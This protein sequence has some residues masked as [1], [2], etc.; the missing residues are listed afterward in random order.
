MTIIHTPFSVHRSPN[1]DALR[2]GRATGYIRAT[3]TCAALRSCSHPLSSS[4]LDRY[5]NYNG[6]AV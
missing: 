4:L 5:A 3:S 6:G 1:I 2:T